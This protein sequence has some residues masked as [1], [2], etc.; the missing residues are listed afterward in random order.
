LSVGLLLISHNELASNLL[1]T[2]TK[3]LGRCPLI[4]ETL[5]VHITSDPGLMQEQAQAMCRDLNQGDGVLILTDMFGSTPSN[6][7]SRVLLPGQSAL[8]TGLNLPML[9]RVL[10]YAHLSL[11]EL[12]AKALSGGRDGVMAVNPP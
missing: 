9:V 12:A 3:M 6:I 10:N 1:E 11:P 8:V 4:T 7:A 2:A 5:A